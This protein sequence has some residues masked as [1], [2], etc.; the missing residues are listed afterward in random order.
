MEKQILKSDLVNGKRVYSLVDSS[1]IV[2]PL[3][4]KLYEMN[5]LNETQIL[6]LIQ[7]EYKPVR[8]R[9]NKDLKPSDII[10]NGKKTANKFDIWITSGQKSKEGFFVIRTGVNVY[11]FANYIRNNKPRNYPYTSFKAFQDLRKDSKK[12]GKY[13]TSI[14]RV[15]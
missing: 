13:V 2:N 7:T 14:L 11:Y 6:R 1:Q 9:T 10:I 3:F 12:F 15:A 4:R 8:V 5:D